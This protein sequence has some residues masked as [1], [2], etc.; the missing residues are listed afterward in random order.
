MTPDMATT[1]NWP[2]D[3]DEDGAGAGDTGIGNMNTSS[4]P[5]G[6]IPEGLQSMPQLAGDIPDIPAAGMDDMFAKG[7]KVSKKKFATGGLEEEAPPPV[8]KPR[9][10]L[11][12]KPL[13]EA[14]APVISTTIV[15]AKKKPTQKKKGGALKAEALPPKRGPEPQGPPA[16]F[17]KGGHVQVP[18]GSG[19]AI[20]GKRFGGIY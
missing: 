14:K 3:E 7:G 19:A 9:A 18:R 16:P 20:R 8:R 4:I 17:R 5:E 12:R 11:V 10:V 2:T 1:G 13:G 15:L 6:A